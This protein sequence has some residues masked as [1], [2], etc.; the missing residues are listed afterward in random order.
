MS[1]RALQSLL[2]LLDIKTEGRLPDVISDFYQPSLDFTPFFWAE[3]STVR[4]ASPAAAVQGFNMVAAAD[5]VPQDEFW[6]C[7][8][9]SVIETAGTTV[10]RQIQCAVTDSAGKNTTI[11]PRAGQDNVGSSSRLA[12]A[13]TGFFLLQPGASWGGWFGV[14]DATRTVLYALTYTPLKI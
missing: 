5:S 12:T 6:L 1:V 8:N 7:T 10:A 11:G 14:A 4:Q 2:P 13:H 3:R 9:L